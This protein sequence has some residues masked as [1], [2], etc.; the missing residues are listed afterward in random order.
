MERII[1]HSGNAHA[2]EFLACAFLAFLTGAPIVRTR[3]VSQDDLENSNIIVVDIGNVFDPEKNN[4]DHHQDRNL[5]CSLIMVL[6]HF[7]DLPRDLLLSIDELR[8]IDEWDRFGPIAV[9]RSW[10]LKLPEFR[11]PISE[12][13]LRIFSEQEVIKPED[14]LHA[15]LRKVGEELINFIAEFKKNIEKAKNAKTFEVKGLKVVQ[16][17]ENVPIRFIKKVHTDVAVVVQPNQRTPGALT[18]TR[19]D[20]HPRVD[21]NRIKDKV[22]AHFIHPNGFMAV[23][24]PEFVMVALHEA[25]FE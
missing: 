14:P 16:L 22:P 24:D 6:E 19:V 10:N 4:F 8:F 21:F 15:V 25:I 2:D 13:V 18:L 23:V 20:D 5:P 3:E 7:L 12:L 1:T 9:Q 11:D 17:E